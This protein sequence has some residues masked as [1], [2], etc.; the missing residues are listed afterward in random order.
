MT[1]SSKY[2]SAA[3][4][5]QIDNLI[6]E[7][8]ASSSAY[9]LSSRQAKITTKRLFKIGG[10]SIRESSIRSEHPSWRKRFALRNWWRESNL[11]PLKDTSL[12]LVT[13]H[14]L[15][16]FR[17][18]EL[19]RFWCNYQNQNLFYRM[20]F[21]RSEVL[22]FEPIQNCKLRKA[23]LQSDKTLLSTIF[24]SFC[25]IKFLMPEKCQNKLQLFGLPVKLSSKTPIGEVKQVVT[26]I[27]SFK[28]D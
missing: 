27:L 19:A 8:W 21:G 6:K 12:F 16:T 25:S 23:D 5:P 10:A 11:Y 22:L 28:I 18:F 2:F 13:N 7:N 4:E 9:V 3:V 1:F 26:K 24:L 17:V 20:L 15:K 14:C